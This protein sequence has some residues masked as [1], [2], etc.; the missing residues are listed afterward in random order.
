M[1]WRASQSLSF[2]QLIPVHPTYIQT[3]CLS[4]HLLTNA[5]RGH[6]LAAVSITAVTTG[7]EV[8]A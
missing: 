3:L 6:V 8:G 2:L 7:V 4:T 1:L 5:R